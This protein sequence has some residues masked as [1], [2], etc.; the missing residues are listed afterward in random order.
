MLYNRIEETS[1]GKLSQYAKAGVDLSA[2]DAIKKRIGDLIASTYGPDV[3]S[4][5]GEFG[6]LFRLPGSGQAVVASVDGVGTKL[7]VA[8]LAERHGTIG[9]DLVNHCVNDIAVMGAKPLFF[10]DY[11]ASGRLPEEVLLEVVSGIV[12]GCRRHSM[13]IL[14]GE[15]AQMPGFYS[16][17]EY[18][19]AGAIFGVANEDQ[20][21]PEF[22]QI[23]AGDSLIAFK[24]NGLHTN[25]YSLARDILFS[26]KKVKVD[27][28]SEELGA[29]WADELL[30]IHR[31]YFHIIRGL[32]DQSMVKGFAHITGGGIPGNLR[33]ILPEGVQASVDISK[34]R[35]PPIF[36]IL[37]EY[38][39]VSLKEMYKVFNMGVGL[40]AI[41]PKSAEDSILNQYAEDAYLIGTLTNLSEKDGAYVVLEGVA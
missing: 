34:I 28:Y 41:C 30:K 2:S 24:S 36:E 38:G 7:R 6:G 39:Q 32:I 3:I 22:D 15:T 23:T 37:M 17:G 16:D 9:E 25:G 5:G 10:L 1:G 14:G 20:T 31:S 13:A 29:S 11:L 8:F 40:V 33:R 4:K 19:L 21:L 18:D 27:D 26:R 12:R 35:V